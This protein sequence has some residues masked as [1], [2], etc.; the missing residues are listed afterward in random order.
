MSLHHLLLRLQV[1]LVVQR[2]YLHPP[3]HFLLYFP[4]IFSGAFNSIFLLDGERRCSILE[5]FALGNVFGGFLGGS[6]MIGTNIELFA[7]S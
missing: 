7:V 6:V 4:S 3:L 1:S 2:L 5:G